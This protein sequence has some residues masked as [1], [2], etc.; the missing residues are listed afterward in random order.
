LAR[1]SCCDQ[2]VA[3][4]LKKLGL[5]VQDGQHTG[6]SNLRLGDFFNNAFLSV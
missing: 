5:T 4:L 3:A 1:D 6:G 2:R